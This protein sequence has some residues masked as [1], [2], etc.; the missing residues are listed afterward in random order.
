MILKPD[1][2]TPRKIESLD[3]P[4]PPY[5]A[6]VPELRARSRSSSNRYG[7]STV[8]SVDGGEQCLDD[9]DQDEDEEDVNLE[10]GLFLNYFQHITF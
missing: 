3:W 10:V 1:P 9:S 7:H 4:A 5:P 6:A 8:Y 2:Q